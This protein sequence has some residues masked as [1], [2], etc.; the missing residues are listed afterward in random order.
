MKV[1]SIA[2][3]DRI[4]EAFVSP[5][6]FTANQRVYGVVGVVYTCYRPPADSWPCTSL[7]SL[8]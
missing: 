2:G 5:H 7:V 8:N 3:M 4:G 6:V 1:H